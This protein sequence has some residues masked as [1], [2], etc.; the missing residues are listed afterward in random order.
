MIHKIFV[1]IELMHEQL[2]FIVEFISRHKLREKKNPQNTKE[3]YQTSGQ[4]WKIPGDNEKIMLKDNWK[5]SSKY[6][7]EIHQF[8]VFY[9]GNLLRAKLKKWHFR[10]KKAKF[11]IHF[12]EK[13]TASS[14]NNWDA[15]SNGK[16]RKWDLYGFTGSGIYMDYMDKQALIEVRSIEESLYCAEGGK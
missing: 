15:R 6:Q 3:W 7:E 13:E 4:W 11:T 16:S 5:I 8:R 1:R 12:S 10:E 9:S 2:L 14:R